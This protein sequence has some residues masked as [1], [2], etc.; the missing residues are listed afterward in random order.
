VRRQAVAVGLTLVVIAVIG[1]L[2]LQ[3]LAESH[4]TRA[5]WMMTRDVPAGSVIASAD[6]EQIRI[7]DTGDAF[8][9]LES[10]PIG[11]RA[12]HQLSTGTL[13]VPGDLLGTDMVLVPLSLR[14][15]PDLATGDSLDVYALVGGQAVLVGRDVIVV[16]TG[17]PL[18]VL[19]PASQEP[20]WIALQAGGVELY[21][22]RSN[23]AGVAPGSSVDVPTAIGQLAG[24]ADGGAVPLPGPTLT[25]TSPRKP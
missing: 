6:V 18:S 24:A 25:P 3:A 19:V 7:P 12:A 9:V 4:D 22:A 21:A 20:Y 13:L 23:G 17:D 15:A 1:L 5:A 11:R 8:T 16:A 2:Y 14:A 10:S